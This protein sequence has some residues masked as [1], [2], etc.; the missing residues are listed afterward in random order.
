MEDGTKVRPLGSRAALGAA[1][2]ACQ[3]KHSDQHSNGM[4]WAASEAGKRH[5]HHYMILEQFVPMVLIW[6]TYSLAY[7]VYTWK[8]QHSM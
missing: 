2:R 3:G 6:M 4:T 1:V 7:Y 8:V 5:Q